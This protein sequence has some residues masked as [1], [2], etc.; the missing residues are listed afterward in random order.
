M[1]G[2]IFLVNACDDVTTQKSAGPVCCL[3]S[4]VFAVPM[5]FGRSPAPYPPSMG[6]NKEKNYLFGG[7]E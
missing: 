2:E 1:S 3:T 7:N 5:A 4:E 6:Y